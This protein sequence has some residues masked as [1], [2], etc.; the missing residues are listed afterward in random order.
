MDLYLLSFI[1]CMATNLILFIPAYSLKTD[2]LTDLSYSLTFIIVSGIA[3]MRSNHSLG[4]IVLFSFVL[5]WAL[6]LGSFLLIRIRNQKRDK[7]FDSIRSNLLLFLRFWIFQAMTVFF[8]MVCSIAF[9]DQATKF[10][11]VISWIGAGVFIAG[12]ILESVADFQKYRFNKTKT[13]DIWIDNGIWRYSRHPNYLGEMMVWLG[14]YLFAFSS[15][16][17]YTRLIG[18]ISPAYIA[19]T[20]LFLSGIP[21]LEKGADKK[22]GDN[23]NYREYKKQVPLLIPKI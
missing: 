21:L 1:V 3:M 5:L 6:R 2:K 4:D 17:T 13:K 12:L 8:V 22:W 15:L 10:I 14:L 16:G 19:F 11:G 9:W 7:R 20:L 18:L 23:P